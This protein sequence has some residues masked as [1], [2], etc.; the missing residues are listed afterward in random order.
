MS[1]MEEELAEINRVRNLTRD[2]VNLNRQKITDNQM[3]N[4]TKT[5]VEIELNYEEPCSY[6]CGK[7]G[8]PILPVVLS[9]LDYKITNQDERYFSHEIIKDNKDFT[10]I[11]ALPTNT[12]L[13]CLFESSYKKI[14]WSLKELSI[15]S[16]GSIKEG[17]SYN[18]DTIVAKKEAN[19][20]KLT[21]N[22][23]EAENDNEEQPFNCTKA[24]HST[25][26]SKFITVGIDETVWMMVS[27]TR[28]SKSTLKRYVDD[29]NLRSIR[30]QKFVG[31]DLV[32]NLNTKI[33]TQNEKQY[34]QSNYR[35]KAL[36]N[37]QYIDSKLLI[38]GNL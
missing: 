8:I 17:V 33:M 38:K 35:R 30:M 6:R 36:A 28:L 15:L 13:Y 14:Y 18:K 10:A 26:A 37:G 16:D 23:I 12:Y 19:N 29:I 20:F 3:I 11:A 5:P 9:Q 22:P 4:N 25:V 7:K 24:Q 21:S 2:A 31:K 27:H 34:I 1:N 32:A